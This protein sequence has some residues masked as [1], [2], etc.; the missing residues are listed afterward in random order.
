MDGDGSKPRGGNKAARPA[1]AP[2]PTQ[3]PA[4]SAAAGAGEKVD[5]GRQ[6]PVAPVD[7][8]RRA[9]GGAEPEEEEGGNRNDDAQ[10]EMFYALLANIR[11]MRRG[12]PPH[13]VAASS[14][15]RGGGG[16]T[17]DDA[18]LDSA[19]EKRL[20]LSADPP[21]RPAFRMEDFEEPAPAA[22]ETRKRT[23]GTGHDGHGDGASSGHE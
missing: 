6:Q 20:R 5:D 10:V 18:V 8:S 1:P 9:A 21:W 13:D 15:V 19:R 7:E 22:C 3:Q 2:D 12:L 16:D 4:S 11:A 17:G 14:S 23:R